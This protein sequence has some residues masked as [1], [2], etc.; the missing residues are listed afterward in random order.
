MPLVS[1]NNIIDLENV[2]DI[3]RDEIPP[4]YLPV[5]TRR[6]KVVNSEEDLSD[7][8][9]ILN[10]NNGSVEDASSVITEIMHQ[11]KFDNTR[12]KAAEI[13]LDLH[14]IRDKEGK[15]NKQPVINFNIVSQEV[16]IANIFSPHLSRDSSSL[17]IFKGGEPT[18]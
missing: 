8:K 17:E 18:D 1:N 11:S 7:I 15:L 6:N 3:L 4:E 12:I 2:T 16:Q 9:K 13:V 14:E 10:R 5:Y